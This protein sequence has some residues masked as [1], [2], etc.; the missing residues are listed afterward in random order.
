MTNERTPPAFAATAGPAYTPPMY[1][2]AISLF[3][4]ACVFIGG[5]S[6]LLLHPK[7]PQSHLT[8]ETQDVVRLGIGML[9]VLAS[10]V[11]GLLIATAKGSSDTTDRDIRS[12]AADVIVLAETLRD[13]GADAA[14]PTS[15][16]RQFTTETLHDIW[17]EGGAAPALADPRTGQTLEHVREAI[18]A[19]R[20]VDA[21]QQWLQDQALTL[22]TSLLRQRW[23]LIEHQGPNVRPVV[24][25][26][27]V[28]WITVIF[29]SFGLNA[30]RNA[31][32]VVAFMVCSMAIGGSV[33]LIIEMDNPFQGAL[34]IPRAPMANALAQMQ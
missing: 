4:T 10:L 19:L 3:V 9:S 24:L 14:T 1:A 27:L 11:L 28:S 17:P 18:R 8:R 5:L 22:V 25:V 13:Y 21:G 23:Q 15:L 2:I 20:P 29:A 30:P 26:I 12:Y 31:T 16:L 34:Q 7:L 33:F 6:G 32:V